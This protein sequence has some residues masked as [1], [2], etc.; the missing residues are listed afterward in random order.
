MWPTPQQVVGLGAWGG[1][2][3]VGAL[4]MIQ[5]FGYFRTLAGGG[6]GGDKKQ[7]A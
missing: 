7:E 5:P 3:V 1:V 4:Y 6:G 2:V